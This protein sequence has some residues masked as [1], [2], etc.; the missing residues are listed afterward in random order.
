VLPPAAACARLDTFTMP[1]NLDIFDEP[2][3]EHLGAAA[4]ESVLEALVEQYPEARVNAMREDIVSIPVP[5]SIKLKR[6]DVVTTQSAYT[7]VEHEGSHILAWVRAKETGLS[8]ASFRMAKMPDATGVMYMFDLRENHGAML[9]VSVMDDADALGRSAIESEIPELLEYTPRF[10]TITKDTNAVITGVD[11]AVTILLGWEADELI[12]RRSIELMHP[13]DHPAAVD[14][15][16]QMLQQPGPARR[17]RQRHQH[18]DGHW[19]WFEVINHNRVSDPEHGDVVGEM[20]D[21]TDE[22]AAL[23]ELHK[24]E[25]LLDRIADAIPVGLVQFDSDLNVVYANDRLY[26]ILGRSRDD[27][28]DM[29][30]RSVYQDDRAL[31]RVAIA[32]ALAGDNPADFEVRVDMPNGESSCV[33]LSVRPLTDDDDDGEITGAILCATDVTDSSRM[34]QELVRRATFDEL[35]GC[36]NRASIMLELEDSIG[37]GR[38]HNERAVV[39][40]DVDHF[41]T[42]NDEHGHSAGD[43]LL[44]VVAGRLRGTVR[45]H[46]VVG[47]VGGDEFVV[48]SPEIGGPDRAM[49]LAARLAVAVRATPVTLPSGLEI[50]VQV[51]VGVAWSHG[52]GLGADTIVARAD[53]AMYESKR[54]RSGLPK[55]ALAA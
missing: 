50:A 35:T 52:D 30:M 54:E 1:L 12:G 38:R 55:L 7:L 14:N 22:M 34:R 32:D 48:L 37:G 18:K 2:R 26:E 25:R 5:D 29:E 39:Y 23:E 17:V 43:E 15:W 6:N 44:R 42:V 41:K 21:I 49:T 33:L 9:T 19:I 36:H 3:D 53:Q 20:A 47:R 10:A 8:R 40:L 11:D 28:I 13:D 27:G 46:D 24:R 45:G 31:L 4:I 51:S 16:L